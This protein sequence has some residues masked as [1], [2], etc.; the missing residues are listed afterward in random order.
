MKPYIMFEYDKNKEKIFLITS[1]NEVKIL[2]IKVWENKIEDDLGTCFCSI[3]NS[4]DKVIEAKKTFNT[5]YS[6]MKININS[7]FS[8]VAII[9]DTV[10]KSLLNINPYFIILYDSL[11]ECTIGI[12]KETKNINELSDIIKSNINRT[13]DD[14]LEAIH[15]FDRFYEG[16]DIVDTI[17][18]PPAIIHANNGN[19]NNKIEKITYEVHSLD[20]LLAV[21]FYLININN[22]H[23][24]RC[25]FLKCNKY[26]STKMGQTKFC[27]NPSPFNNSVSCRNAKKTIEIN[28]D[29]SPWQKELNMIKP[30]V[31]RSIKF[32]FDHMK[33]STNKREKQMLEKNYERLKETAREFNKIIKSCP[34]EYKMKYLKQYKEYIQEIRTN[35]LN[36][37][38]YRVKVFKLQ[39][40]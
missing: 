16:N 8:N 3:L 9:V 17:Y 19:V 12:I 27:N 25:G 35:Q 14:I 7:I 2:Q 32:L 24:K 20:D 5:N 15:V 1:K 33:L 37:S 28:F 26:F 4:K 39:K 21:S 36:H 31:D 6:N 13:F 11:F 18:L 10:L 40:K 38:S 34:D 22:Y 23:I 29:E 30:D